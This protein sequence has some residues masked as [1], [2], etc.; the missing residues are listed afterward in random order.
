M[1]SHRRNDVLK[2]FR[3]IVANQEGEPSKPQLKDRVRISFAGIDN[4]IDDDEAK[5]QVPML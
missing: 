5:D 3:Q 2:L 1:T 4:D